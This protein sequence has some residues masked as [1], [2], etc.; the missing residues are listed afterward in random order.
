MTKNCDVVLVS[1]PFG[2]LF[3]PSLGLSLFKSIL[4][5]RD[6]DSKIVYF[7]HQF[8]ELVSKDL[9]QQV[10]NGEPSRTDMLGEWIFSGALFKSNEGAKDNYI[11]DV[12][13]GHSPEHHF[14]RGGA[15]SMTER[16]IESIEYARA[17]AP[18]FI[19]RCVDEVLALKP[20]IVGIT[21]IFE[22]QTAA[23]AFAKCLKQK[24]PQTI[25]ALG[26]SNCDG[27]MGGEIA[28][29]FRFLDIVVS[30]EAD[31]VFPQLVEQVLANEP[32]T[33]IRGVYYPSQSDVI[34]SSNADDQ[35]TNR[36][37][38]LNSLPFP[39]FVD[40][41]ENI[42]RHNYMT[43]GLIAP[44]MAF[45]TA[46]GCWWGERKHCT[47]C[48]L[49]GSSMAFRSKS[50]ERA[51]AEL[52]YLVE[53]YPDYR[54][55]ITDNII[56]HK[57]FKTFL[58]AL[59]AKKLPTKLFYEVKSNLRE[60]QIK[61]LKEAGV[62][63]I[64]PGI[65][66]FSD[67]VLQT[68]NKGVTGL[69]NIQTLKW[70][71]EHGVSP[72]W[73][74][75]WGFANESPQEYQWMCQIIPRLCHLEPPSA[76]TQIRMDRFSPNH[77]TPEAMGFTNV[78]PFPSY[79]YVYPGLSESTVNNLAYFFSYDYVKPQ[80][81]NP[82]IAVMEKLCA[83]WMT[84]KHS[85]SL[86]YVEQNGNSVVFDLR[87]PKLNTVPLSKNESW[88]L[89]LC[90]EIKSTKVLAK[91]TKITT[92]ELDVILTALDEKELIVRRNNKNLSL[93]FDL[94]KHSPSKGVLNRFY[95]QINEIG[96]TQGDQVT[97]AI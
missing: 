38:N 16:F 66:S 8:A 9:Y 45:E 49:N 40:F 1:L 48:G 2:P 35:V 4:A 54:I 27:I 69:E 56:D 88:I 91:L 7:T 37:D 86:F 39:D 76:T 43:S 80:A 12:I 25:V 6:I 33:P 68:M 67:K 77:T 47:F 31:T 42:D 95:A 58:P 14:K 28:R 32:L 74:I 55:Y 24:S 26:G 61:L 22:T 18:A 65:E 78:R 94:A 85:P 90:N 87:K 97:I 5:Q 59:A 71:A 63:K 29:T 46:R 84:Q 20:K 15:E 92:A 70:C 34:Y 36:T 83:Q 52:E 53:Q 75:L 17:Q 72:S 3:I 23:L 73:G 21:S 19:E 82:H 50:P 30:G 41:T 62:D 64:Q 79:S 81:P 10:S 96:T 93:V 13:R 44:Y 60:D 51:L 89:T 11:N 57:Y